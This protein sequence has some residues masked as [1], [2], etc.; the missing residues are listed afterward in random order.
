MAR[1]VVK[2][3][4]S[5]RS[6]GDAEEDSVTTT[7]FDHKPHCQVDAERLPPAVVRK[8]L[9]QRWYSIENVIGR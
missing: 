6:T 3:R 2:P 5:S 7:G 1:E 4:S 9:V 8:T